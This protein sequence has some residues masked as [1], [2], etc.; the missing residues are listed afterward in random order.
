LSF[1]SLLGAALTALWLWEVAVE[2]IREKVAGLDVHRDRVVAC[3]R[4]ATGGGRVKTVKRSFSTMSD[5]IVELA[6]WLGDHA[7]TTAVM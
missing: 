4:V 6:G 2:T 7:I 1:R 5:G 3:A